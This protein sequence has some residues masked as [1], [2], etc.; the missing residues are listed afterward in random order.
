M[1][2]DGKGQSMAP[3]YGSNKETPRDFYADTQVWDAVYMHAAQE[4]KD[5]MQ[6][7]YLT[8]QRPA[9]V[10]KISIHDLTDDFLLVGQGKPRSD[11]AYHFGMKGWRPS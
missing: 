8:G 10:L 3:V 2:A 1:G 9:D 5:A 7:A 11:C 6:L 4:L